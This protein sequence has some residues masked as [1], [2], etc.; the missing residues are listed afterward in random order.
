MAECQW[1]QEVT[2]FVQSR[3]INGRRDPKTF[4]G[5]E[6]S[7]QRK[8]LPPGMERWMYAGNELAKCCEGDFGKCPMKPYGVTE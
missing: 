4:E 2:R 5:K 7:C 1:Y 8:V 3:S 6:R